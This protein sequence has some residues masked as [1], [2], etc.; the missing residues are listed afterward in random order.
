MVVNQAIEEHVKKNTRREND[1]KWH[2]SQ[3]SAPCPR[4]SVLMKRG[5][6]VSGEPNVAQLK[7]FAIGTELHKFVQ[8]AMLSAPGVTYCYPE[9]EV[10]H[11][12]VSGAA[13]GLIWYDTNEW[14]LL[15]LK[16]MKSGGFLY[17][18][19]R[20]EHRI[21]AGTYAWLARDYGGYV[22]ELD[23]TIP[24]LGDKLQTIRFAYISKNMDKT[25]HIEERVESY[26]EEL[27]RGV[28]GR[29]DYLRSL[30]QQEILPRI[31]DKSKWYLDYCP[32]R[33]SGQ[34]CGDKES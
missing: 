34:C 10:G 13:D 14:E 30:E 32:Y 23:L 22:R 26:T 3:I 8:K 27:E 29:L 28:L 18:L 5:V 1:K 24:P 9:V 17:G 33:G 31:P 12:D 16:S 7:V 4:S 20:K 6:L 15:E 11:E 19:P 21:Q 25:L 2:P